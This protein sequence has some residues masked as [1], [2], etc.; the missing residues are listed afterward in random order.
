MHDVLGA[1]LKKLHAKLFKISAIANTA[2][3]S[4]VRL[5]IVKVLRE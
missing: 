5:N 2:Y 4:T 3:I 1:I